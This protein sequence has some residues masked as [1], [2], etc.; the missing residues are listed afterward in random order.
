M[1]NQDEEFPNPESV[2][3]ARAAVAGAD[4]LWIVTPEYQETELRVHCVQQLAAT[5]PSTSRGE[6]I[7]PC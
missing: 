1:F 4:A 2:S 5:K 3:A 6:R 7:A